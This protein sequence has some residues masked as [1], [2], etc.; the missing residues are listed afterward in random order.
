VNKQ[1]QEKEKGNANYLRLLS[2]FYAGFVTEETQVRTSGKI[3]FKF[4]MFHSNPSRL[5]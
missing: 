3:S 5:I 1:I 4:C 2:S